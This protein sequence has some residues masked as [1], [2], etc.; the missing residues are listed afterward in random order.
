MDMRTRS[1]DDARQTARFF[2]FC[3]SLVFHC[4]TLHGIVNPLG[5]CRTYGVVDSGIRR[6]SHLVVRD[7]PR[8]FVFLV[9]GDD[10][11]VLEVRVST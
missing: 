11:Q 7:A 4:K 8:N 6:M 5:V 9:W 1:S 2:A 10:T 3:A